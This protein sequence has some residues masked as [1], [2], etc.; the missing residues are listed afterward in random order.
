M[1]IDM[2]VRPPYK[3]HLTT[4]VF[5]HPP[6]PDDPTLWSIFDIG[7]VPAPSAV[8]GSLEL[9]LDEMEASGTDRAVIMGRKADDHGS[10]DNDEVDEL[11]R[12][13]PD[14]FIPFAGVNPLLPGQVEE[15]ERV[16]HLGFRGAA[17]DAGWL[18]K[19]LRHDDPLLDPI[20]AACERLG[21]I[22][23]ITSSFML[24]PDLSYSDPA[25]I[26]RVALRHPKLNIVV[27]HGCW[28]HVHEALAV[29]IRCRNVYLMPDCYVAIEGFPL[30]EEYVRAANT[31]LRYRI[32]Y[33]SSYP[34]RS[35]EQSL[36][37][38]RARGFAPEV[39]PDVLGNNALRLLGER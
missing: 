4:S 34:V 30:A 39:L 13:H 31:Y 16:A 35:L 12:A 25:A 27:P 32:V 10:V 5:R 6:L 2:R 15:L 29:A 36:A 11:A 19:P 9:F 37:G 8:Q 1:I 7:K 28:P 3:G 18:R 17:V 21:L 20:Y 26:Q 14:R 22:I 23:S 38:W 33:A 24:G